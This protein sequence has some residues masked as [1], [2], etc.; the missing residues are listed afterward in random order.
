MES[1]PRNCGRFSIFTVGFTEPTLSYD[2]TIIVALLKAIFL[3]LIWIDSVFGL[4]K[5]GI[6]RK[7]KNREYRDIYYN[8]QNYKT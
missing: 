5:M 3:K 7:D 2:R 8:S 6:N 4:L 1:F